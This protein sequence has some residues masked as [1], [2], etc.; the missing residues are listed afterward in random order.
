MSPVKCVCGFSPAEF[1]TPK[2]ELVQKFQ[3]LYL[4]MLPV[5]RP[6]GQSDTQTHTHTHTH[7]THANCN[8]MQSLSTDF[9]CLRLFV[10]NTL[11][12]RHGHTEWSYR[13][14]NRFFQQRGLDSG[15]PQCGRCYCHHQQR[16]GQIHTCHHESLPP[17]SPGFLHPVLSSFLCGKIKYDNKKQE[18]GILMQLPSQAKKQPPFC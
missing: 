13:E 1:P 17:G 5:A 2:T 16:Q 6:I 8:E 3:V 15:S 4:G 10:F 12:C 9:N 18:S 7:N 11:C 14:F